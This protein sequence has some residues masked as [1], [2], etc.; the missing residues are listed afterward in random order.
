MLSKDVIRDVEL[1]RCERCGVT[2]APKLQ[3]AKL[4][5]I[6][7][8]NEIEMAL[9]NHCN[10]CKKIVGRKSAI[11]PTEWD[12]IGDADLDVLEVARTQNSAL[13]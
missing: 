9:L 7:T 6:L 4:G 2:I 13:T 8:A 1:A 12:S 5:S 10:R 11:L 3:T